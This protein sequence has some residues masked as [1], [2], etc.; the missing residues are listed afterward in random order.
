MGKSVIEDRENMKIQ[1][2]KNI[3]HWGG[4]EAKDLIE[5]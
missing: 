3:I 5:V 1:A 4:A 2:Y